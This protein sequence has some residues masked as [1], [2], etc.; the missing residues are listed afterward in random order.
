MITTG[1]AAAAER[2]RYWEGERERGRERERERKRKGKLQVPISVF[3]FLSTTSNIARLSTIK[4]EQALNAIELIK[5][6]ETSKGSVNPNW[7]EHLS[8]FNLSP[9]PDKWSI[10]SRVLVSG[11]RRTS[12]SSGLSESSE[13]G[14]AWSGR[15]W[16]NSLHRVLIVISHFLATPLTLTTSN[17]WMG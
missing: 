13:D 4:I 14:V 11:A 3:S 16:D 1:A 7:T 9:F 10:N 5:A 15:E 6:S 17:L 8:T 12:K 2:Y